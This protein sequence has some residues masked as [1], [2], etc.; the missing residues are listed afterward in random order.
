[1]TEAGDRAFRYAFDLARRHQ[2]QLDIFFF[3]VPPSVPHEPRGR[4]GRE[5]MMDEQEAIELERKVRLYYD[6]LLGDYVKV[7]FRLCFGDEAPELRRCLFDREYDVL[8]LSRESPGEL[9]GHHPVEEFADRLQCPVVLIGPEEEGAYLLNGPARL[10]VAELGLAGRPWRPLPRLHLPAEDRGP[11][12]GGGTWSA[13][14]AEVSKATGLSTFVVDETGR[15]LTT[16]GAFIHRLGPVVRA[17]RDSAEALCGPLPD[18]ESPVTVADVCPA[19]LARIVVPL[20]LAGRGRGFL[21]CCGALLE[22]RT[23]D[24]AHIVEA[25]GLRR[26]AVDHLVSQ[27]ARLSTQEVKARAARVEAIVRDRVRAGA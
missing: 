25:T 2:T 20:E 17:H 14:E 18:P 15:N 16:E 21:F 19:G 24:C 13:L 26:E 9:F 5:A 7:G 6:D 23:A 12:R 4:R 11:P 10:W 3:P 1:M 22:G 27:L 8:V